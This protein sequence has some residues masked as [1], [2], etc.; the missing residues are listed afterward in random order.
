M[1]VLFHLLTNDHF[2]EDFL[3]KL[4]IQSTF[5]NISLPFHEVHLLFFFLSLHQ[6]TK[7]FLAFI[8]ATIRALVISIA[9][10]LFNID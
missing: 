9:C 1:P 5:S 3:N 8:E 10:A 4:Y 6:L 7:E 2:Q